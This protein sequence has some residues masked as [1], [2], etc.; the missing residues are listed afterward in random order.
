[1]K[2]K[3]I[4]EY[5]LLP[6]SVI[7]GLSVMVRNKLFD[8][9]LLPSKEFNIPVISVGNIRVGG[10]GKTP[11]IEYLVEL[12]RKDYRV[13][14]LSRGYKRKTRGF[15]LAGETTGPDQIG[16]EPCQIKQKFP[17]I[18]VAV[19]EKR[20]R[21]IHKLMLM[22]PGPDVILLDD[23]FQHRY[24][25][26]G[27]SILLDDFQHSMR[28]DALL[29]SGR[30]R[31]P[32]QAKKRADIILVT[33]SPPSLKAIDMRIRARETMLDEFQ[34]L[35]YTRII[36][37]E[38]YGLFSVKREKLNLK[39]PEIL[40]VTGIANPRTVKPLVRKISTSIKEINFSDHHKYTEKDINRIL[41]LFSVMDPE[42][43]IILTTEKDAVK[44]REFRNVF[45]SVGEKIFY[46]TI[47]VEFLNKDDKNFNNQI[48]DYVRSNKRNSVLYKK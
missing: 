26:P 9:N 20:S 41:S 37:K 30:L 46:L 1:M 43:S 40:L 25:K 11:H 17:E 5:L 12:L 6:L 2:R 35:Y 47:S 45:D 23:A 8:L 4:P 7:Y 13:A 21:G 38:I 31:E 32:W 27:L 19:D 28:K 36:A 34:H 29:P 48:L 3:K 16:D 18:F 14:V 24:V 42:N 15:V 33:K 39:K 22:I 10:T 44:L